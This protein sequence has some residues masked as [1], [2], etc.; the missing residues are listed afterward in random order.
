MYSVS[1]KTCVETGLIFHLKFSREFDKERSK[2][3]KKRANLDSDSEEDM[4][5]GDLDD[6]LSDEEVDFGDLDMGDMEDWEDGDSDGNEA[7]SREMAPGKDAG[8]D[9]EE[10]AFSDQ[11]VVDLSFKSYK[12]GTFS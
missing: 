5:G 12:S 8:F 9:E 10:V 3:K 7:G 6:D 2:R 11:G 1:Q 4:D